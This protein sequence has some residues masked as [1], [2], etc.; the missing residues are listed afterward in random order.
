MM[1]SLAEKIKPYI[2]VGHLSRN[3]AI[4]PLDGD[5]VGY[6]LAYP[7]AEGFNIDLF[8]MENGQAV[9]YRRE[10]YR[11]ASLYEVLEVRDETL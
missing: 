3:W 8:G 7:D 2:T 11:T 10:V 5:K 9:V 4:I 6:L 1:Q